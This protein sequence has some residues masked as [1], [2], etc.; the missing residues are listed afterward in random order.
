[1]RRKIKV[2]HIIT[3][4]AV[5]GSQENTIFT[6]SMLDNNLY[7]TSI[8]CGTERDEEG[9][10][11]GMAKDRKV[12]LFFIPELIR[13]IN[14]VKDFTALLRIKKFI[15]NG[16]Y[17]IVHTHTSKAG[18]VGRLAAKIDGVPVIIHT[19]H[20]WNFNDFMNPIKKNFYVLCERIAEKFTDKIIVV[21][22]ED[23]KKGFKEGIRNKEKYEV[24]RSGIDLEQFFPRECNTVLK[25][26][27][28]LK[29]ED[30]VIGTVTRI[31]P[32]KNIEDFIKIADIVSNKV[33]NSKFLIVGDGKE[34]NR[35]EAKIKKLQL[36]DRVFI[37]GVRSDIPEILSI[38][39]VF[40]STSLWEGLPRTIVEA[41]AC[42]V[43]VIA[44]AVDGVREIIKNRKNGFLMPPKDV[45]RTSERV[46]QILNRPE[47]GEYMRN[48]ARKSID[49][50]SV[51]KMVSSIAKLYIKLL[52][53]VNHNTIDKSNVY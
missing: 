35:I 39:D 32:Q 1:M 8:L 29:K 52:Y 44:Y 49:E 53:Q 41:I 23:I 33:P 5:G 20:G 3:K 43:P 6:C 42:G 25:T 12:P 10:L 7:D 47:I 4:L 24:I 14:P 38:F 21:T 28:G 18:M 31:C 30:K 15:K 50:F 27:L 46:I 22:K 51:N 45:M 36:E 34:R 19:V 13:D 37:T 48:E 9:D 2:L 11:I 17:D 16:K 26:E 40:V